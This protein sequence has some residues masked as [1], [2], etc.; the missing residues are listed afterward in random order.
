MEE[1]YQLRDLLTELLRIEEKVGL[2]G[3]VD[4]DGLRIALARHMKANGQTRAVIYEEA[5]RQGT[6]FLERVSELCGYPFRTTPSHTKRRV[7]A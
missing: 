3:T 2:E 7:R 6:G 4:L 1:S 5:Q